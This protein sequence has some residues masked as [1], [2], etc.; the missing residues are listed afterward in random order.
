MERKYQI[1]NNNYSIVLPKNTEN[2]IVTAFVMR[3]LMTLSI[4]VLEW[5]KWML[6]STIFHHIQQFI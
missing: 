2:N 4:L 5:M 1:N 6:K 3:V